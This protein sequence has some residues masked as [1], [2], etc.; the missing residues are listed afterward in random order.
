[1]QHEENE[2]E[3]AIEGEILPPAESSQ[4][5]SQA[6]VAPPAPYVRDKSQDLAIAGDSSPGNLLMVAVQRGAKIE[7]LQALMA[8]KQEY[9][10]DEAR[11]AYTKAM[12][13][14][15]QDAPIIFK[16]KHVSFDTSS[17]TT[18]YNHATLGAVCLV[19]GEALGR[20]G[21]SHRWELDQSNGALIKCTCIITHED[22]HSEQ[23]EMSGPADSSG[24]KNAIQ[25]VA[26]T[27]TYLERYTLLSA[28]GMSAMEDDSGR[29]LD[30]DGVTPD[31]LTEEQCAEFQG[32]INK[33]PKFNLEFFF[34]TAKAES[35][36]TIKANQYK[37]LL[38][39]LEVK[40]NAG[41]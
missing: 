32:L 33:I 8:L 21:L 24:G 22:G 19:I 27:V 15:K 41:N 12:A 26:S 37:R 23:T 35:L 31:Y 28:T 18:S 4:E 9:E 25:G 38:K 39:V 1:M 5:A 34:K 17:G 13:M 36:E 16:D 10:A 14:F 7:E 30:Q 40:A 11:K 3:T 20:F 6:E 2:G 29:A